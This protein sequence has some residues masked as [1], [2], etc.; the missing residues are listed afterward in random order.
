MKPR[1]LLAYSI[2]ATVVALDLVTKR[3]AS[4]TFSSEPVPL[5]P[6]LLSLR[7]VENPGAAFGVFENAGPLLGMAAV[8]AVGFVTSALFRPRPAYETV[9]F[10]LIIGGALGNLVDRI[11]R[12][13][14]FLDGKVI[15]WIDL[16]PIPTFNVAD[17]AITLA[18][19][20]L[21]L[22]SWKRAAE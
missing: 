19:A 16:R 1:P 3:W 9:A 15:D 2:A 6:G 4:A 11:S 14:G 21:L 17:S 18:V 20:V 10:G 22:G 7:F 5:I 13:P 8:I 12:G